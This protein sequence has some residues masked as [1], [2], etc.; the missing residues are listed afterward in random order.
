MVVIKSILLS[1]LFV[2]ENIIKVSQKWKFESLSEK[3][4]IDLRFLNMKVG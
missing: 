3:V 4:I 1:N 2:Y